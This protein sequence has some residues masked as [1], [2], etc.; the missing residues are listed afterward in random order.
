[1]Q[2]TSGIGTSALYS[3]LPIVVEVERRWNSRSREP[4]WG[5]STFK[6]FV[7]VELL[8]H[9]RHKNVLGPHYSQPGNKCVAC[10]YSAGGRCHYAGWLHQAAGH[11]VL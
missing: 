11:N 4:S 10:F 1:M 9:A 2:S 6:S 8:R 7:I 3:L 5:Q